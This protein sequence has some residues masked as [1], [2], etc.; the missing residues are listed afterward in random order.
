MR[1]YL[2]AALL[3]ALVAAPAVAQ[4]TLDL[5]KVKALRDEG[6]K[7]FDES[8]NVD[9]DNG[10]RN[11]HRKKSYALVSEAYA[12]LDAWCDAHPEDIEKYEDL[13]VELGQMRYWLRKESPVGL[14]D[15]DS[16]VRKGI[17]PD[18]PSEPPPDLKDPAL[19]PR[20]TP[21]PSRPSEE[22]PAP[23]PQEDGI[24]EHLKYAEE[25]AREHPFDLPGIRDLYLDILEHAQPG[26]APYVTALKKISDLNSRMKGFYRRLRDED[27]DQLD[28]SG[29]EERRLVFA[30][31]KDLKDREADVR[32]RAAEYLGLLGCGDAARHLVKQVE[33]EDEAAVREMIFV[34]LERIGG[35]KVT[36]EVKELRKGRD[37][38]IQR[39]ALALLEKFAGRSDVEARYASM[40][41]GE[42]IFSRF[43]PIVNET[44]GML[45]GLGPKGVYGLANGIT[46]RDHQQKLRIIAALGKTGDGR[47]AGPLSNL[48]I[49]GS[50]GR[51]DEYKRAAMEAIKQIGRPGVPYLAAAVDHPRLR[52]WTKALLRE[53]TGVNFESGAAVKAWWE[54]NGE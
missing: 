44:I 8:A 50:K 25:Y 47:A 3:A 43:D 33:H 13:M 16:N 26:S 15:D 49:F 41:L 14:L 32:L 22:N 31:S 39:S 28:L 35:S 23:P 4:D 1:P 51:L 5:A 12:I 6:K 24:E 10:E 11:Q 30:L 53:M 54:R 29:T 20:E 27:P 42:F 2:F 46:V 38:E 52:Q 19:P 18:W 40:A 7:H 21:A 34:A 37:E 17:P 45:E 48:L 9:L 36:E